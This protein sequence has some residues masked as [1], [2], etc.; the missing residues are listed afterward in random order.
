[1]RISDKGVA[2]KTTTVRARATHLASE[3]RPRPGIRFAPTPWH[4]ICALASSRALTSSRALA[5][6]CALASNRSWNYARVEPCPGSNHA[7]RE[8]APWT[9]PCCL[10]PTRACLD[11]TRACLDPT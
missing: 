11:P 1:M 4:P 9:D 5:S 3:L 10:D 2:L 6:N 7:C 8:A